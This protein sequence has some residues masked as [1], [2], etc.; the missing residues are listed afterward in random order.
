MKHETYSSSVGMLMKKGA[1]VSVPTLLSAYLNISDSFT[2]IWKATCKVV[3][4][5]LGV[6]LGADVCIYVCTHSHVQMHRT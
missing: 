3:W 5:G 4:H 6:D 2:V 1:I